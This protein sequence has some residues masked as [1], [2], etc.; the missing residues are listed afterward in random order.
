MLF[1]LYVKVQ[2]PIRFINEGIK[3]TVGYIHLEPKKEVRPGDKMF[4][5]SS[6]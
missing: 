3:E 4:G 1:W 2:I 5:V 6:V